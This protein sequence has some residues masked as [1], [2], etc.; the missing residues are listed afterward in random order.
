MFGAFDFGIQLVN[1]KSGFIKSP[2]KVARVQSIVHIFAEGL[3]Y[4]PDKEWADSMIHQCSVFPRG[5]HDDLVD[6][7]SQAFLYMRRTG[8]AVLVSERRAQEESELMFKGKSENQPL[9]P[10]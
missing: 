2:D 10:A 3:V 6:S 7:M 9:Y 1:P 5:M 8:L 4:A